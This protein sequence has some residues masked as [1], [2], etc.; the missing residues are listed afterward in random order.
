M[1]E[2]TALARTGDDYEPEPTPPAGN[3]LQRWNGGEV[4]ALTSLDLTTNAGAMS[5]LRCLRGADA[6]AKECTGGAIK[7]RDW[8]L[9]QVKPI[10]N[11]DGEVGADLRLVFLL[12][13]GRTVSTRSP[14]VLDQWRHTVQLAKLLRWE[15]PLTIKLR[16]VKVDAKRSYLEI[17]TIT[18]AN[19]DQRKPK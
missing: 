7:V 3:A 1:S 2:S 16:A 8:F 18:P 5:Y 12:D 4:K 9:H 19:M 14:A 6:N 17:E 10:V 13:D 11:D 15:F